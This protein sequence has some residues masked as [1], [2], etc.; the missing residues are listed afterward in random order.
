MTAATPQS[1][2]G[3]GRQYID[4]ADIAAVIAVLKG[5]R[6]TEGPAVAEFETL[7]K[8]RVGAGDAVACSNGTAALHLAVMALGVGPGDTVV[9]PAITFAAT[10][11]AVRYVGGEVVFADVDGDT[12]LMAA[13][14]LDSA[15]DRSRREGKRV[16]AVFSVHMGGQAEAV[17]ALAELAGREGAVLIEDAC[18]ALGT[19]YEQGAESWMVG[20]CA[21]SV[22]AA[23][24]FHPVKTVTTGEGGAVAVN[25]PALA[26]R[27]R[28]LRSH[29]INRDPALF[30]Q[31]DLAV[32]DDAVNPWYYEM[33]DLGYNYRLCDIQAALG[34]SQLG[35]LDAF[36]AR[37]QALVERYDALLAGLAP[38]ILPPGRIAGC[39]PGWH[40]YM[41]RFDFKR[42]GMSRGQLMRALAA[43]G[44]GTQ[45]HYIPVP[46]L[47]Y[48]R[49]IVG[50]QDLP[51]AARHYGQCLSLP[52][53]PGMDLEHVDAVVDALRKILSL[54]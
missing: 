22:M 30:Q 28:R 1:L 48:W 21:H 32:E 5:E 6:L 23:F 39:K 53:H 47:P 31:P 2:S 18:H 10:A 37:R 24:S 54:H 20:D 49:Q 7:L 43:R 51:G 50:E 52:L 3:Y 38:A 26:V 25:D 8:Q 15:L 14:Q 19:R 13:G 36:I 29:G 41:A 42:L 12:G 16:K 45:V 9:V 4:D 35:K 11:N 46:W 40:L 27:L 44:I 34:I 33:I 17:P